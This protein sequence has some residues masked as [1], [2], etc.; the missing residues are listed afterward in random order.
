MG[1]WGQSSHVH[2]STPDLDE[3]QNVIGDQSTRRPHLGGE[4]IRR[5]QEVTMGA[6]TLSPCRRLFPFRCRWEVVTFQD[7][8]DRLVNS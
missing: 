4:E 5:H 1:V 3:E 7:V 2:L 6:N 8:A